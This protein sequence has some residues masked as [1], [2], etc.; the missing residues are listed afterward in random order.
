[1]PKGQFLPLTKDQEDQMKAEYLSKPVKRLADELNIS[2]GRIM[3]FLKTNGLEIPPE[4]IEQRKLN[5]R[6]KKGDPAFNKGRKQ[7]DYMTAE[8]IER[9]KKT[10]F[11]KGNIP[12]NTNKE[13]NGA[14]VSRRDTCGR[15]YKYIR[16]SKGVWDLYHRILWEQHNGKI[17]A[18]HVI[19]FKDG[20]SENVVLENLELITMIENMYRNAK[21][22]FPQE[23]IP[24][25]VLIKQLE[26]K[27]NILQDGQ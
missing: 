10:R 24:S 13:G 21:Y 3:R 8:A 7:K 9:T 25:L 26:N 17:P 15:N 12:H 14:I 19:V 2:F 4:V 27:L 16:I 23:V 22:K 6:K 11:K 1:M 5:S 18:N 20:D